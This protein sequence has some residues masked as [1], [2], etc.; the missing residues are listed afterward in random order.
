MS[1]LAPFNIYWRAYGGVKALFASP[2]IYIALIITVLFPDQW[3]IND[4][5]NFAWASYALTVVPA[6]LSFS[7][8]GFAIFLAFVNERLMNEIAS[9]SDDLHDSLYLEVC[10][11]FFH[12]ILIGVIT[13]FVSLLL[14]DGS[15]LND[16]FVGVSLSVIGFSFFAYNIL[17]I[18]AIASL[19]LQMAFLLNA[20]EIYRAQDNQKNGDNDL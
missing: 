6:T 16:T 15:S 17:I 18:I 19:L 3:S 4:K 11:N 13:I 12:F 5:K 1:E 7:V 2:Y 9:A 20:S 14:A 10:A 8:G